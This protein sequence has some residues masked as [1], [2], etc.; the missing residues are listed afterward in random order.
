MGA[1]RLDLRQRPAHPRMVGEVLCCGSGCTHTRGTLGRALFALHRP[2]LSHPA[3][4]LLGNPCKD[5]FGWK[6]GAP[7]P[8]ATSGQGEARFAREAPWSHPTLPSIRVVTPGP[9]PPPEPASPTTG[10]PLSQGAGFSPAAFLVT[11]RQGRCRRDNRDRDY[12]QGHERQTAER[13]AFHA[14]ELRLKSLYK[15]LTRGPQTQHGANMSQP[16]RRPTGRC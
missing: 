1:G 7:T 10:R 16:Y 5:L 2:L 4:E 8:R 9:S 14:R 13:H 6:V 11:W 3:T 12:I 15:P